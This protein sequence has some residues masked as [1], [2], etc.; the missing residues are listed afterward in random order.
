MKSRYDGEIGGGKD[1]TLS[2]N[3]M[4]MTH[5]GMLAHNRGLQLGKDLNYMMLLRHH[6]L[7]GF[8]AF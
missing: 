6:S 1:R 7:S 5:M 2:K 8:P 4:R 3:I